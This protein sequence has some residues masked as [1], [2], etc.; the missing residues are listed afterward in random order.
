MTHAPAARS[1]YRVRRL[2]WLLWILAQAACRSPD[3]APAGDPAPLESPLTAL[4][5]KTGTL[6]VIPVEEFERVP[7]AVVVLEDGRL[8]LPEVE[9]AWIHVTRPDGE[10]LTR[11]GGPAAGA[12]PGNV[13]GRFGSLAGVAPTPG[14][15]LLAADRAS[16]VLT[17]FSSALAPDSSFTL[18]ETRSVWQIEALRGGAYAAAVSPRHPL[19][20]GQVL[21]FGGAD[22]TRAW[23]VPDPIFRHNRW[24]S[25][26]STR[27]ESLTDGRLLAYWSPLPWARVLSTGG[28]TLP[29]IGRF[30]RRYKGPPSGPPAGAALPAL[31]QWFASWTPLVT[32]ESVGTMVLFQFLEA[33]SPLDSV[34]TGRA[35]SSGS[36]ARRAAE[37]DGAL[38]GK[39][40]RRLFVNVYDA[41]GRPLAQDLLLPA[42]SRILRSNDRDHLYVLTGASRR[43]LEIEVWEPR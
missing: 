40:P 38:A 28:D 7:D 22:S 19:A 17:A 13:A 4:L 39:E 31:R 41:T 1:A 33:A 12:R 2:S 32:V 5:R 24:E 18:P 20:G 11:L 34:G 23:F 9:G 14:G 25:V 3:D 8:V 30:S 27:I 16:G 10:G 26:S 6:R 42:G 29:P 21:T 43:G 15:G 35:R 36:V 37:P